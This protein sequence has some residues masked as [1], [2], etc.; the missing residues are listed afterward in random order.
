MAHVRKSRP[1]SGHGSLIK[2]LSRCSLFAR[3]R[4]ATSQRRRARCAS[5]W[6]GQVRFPVSNFRFSISGFWFPV[7]GSRFLVP[8][9]RFPV[10]SFRFPVPDFR[11]PASVSGFWF[12][13]SRKLVGGG[14]THQRCLSQFGRSV[15]AIPGSFRLRVDGFVP[16][17]KDVDL[18]IVGQPERGPGHRSGAGRDSHP[19]GRSGVHRGINALAAPLQV[20]TKRPTP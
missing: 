13:V 20:H 11:F 5:L 1:D 3:K 4:N 18:S 15:L 16:Q 7:S 8:G 12:P 19:C 9:F 2:S 10:S 14:G 17:S 6:G